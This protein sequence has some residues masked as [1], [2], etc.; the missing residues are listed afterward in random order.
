MISTEPASLV[1]PCILLLGS[2]KTVIM[3]AREK[4]LEIGC[5]IWRRASRSAQAAHRPTRSRRLLGMEPVRSDEFAEGKTVRTPHE[6]PFLDEPR[7]GAGD[8]GARNKRCDDLRGTVAWGN[9]V[10]IETS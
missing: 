10:V 9:G 1:A 3:V 4:M 2:H 6:N 8:S 5:P 7:F